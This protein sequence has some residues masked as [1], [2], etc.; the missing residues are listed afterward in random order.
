MDALHDCN[1]SRA[2]GAQVALIRN[3]GEGVAFAAARSRPLNFNLQ[4]GLGIAKKE[5]SIEFNLQLQGRTF[6][7]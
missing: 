6:R 5:R 2:A 1:A 7:N 4:R 3:S